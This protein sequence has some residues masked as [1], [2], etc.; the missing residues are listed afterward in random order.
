MKPV[1]HK[2]VRFKKHYTNPI[3]CEVSYRDDIDGEK[4]HIFSRTKWNKVTCKKCL[5]KLKRRRRKN[6][7]S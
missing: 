5:A 2:A 6:E 4:A 7:D 3:L 1:I